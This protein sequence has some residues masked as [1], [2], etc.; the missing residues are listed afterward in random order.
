M[1]LRPWSEVNMTIEL[2]EMGWGSQDDIIRQFVS[3]HAQV[4]LCHTATDLHVFSQPATCQNCARQVVDPYLL[5]ERVISHFSSAD[6]LLDKLYSSLLPTVFF[7]AFPIHSSFSLSIDPSSV[8]R[9]ISNHLD[10][11]IP[12][13]CKYL[14]HLQDKPCWIFAYTSPS[15]S[16]GTQA[17]ESSVKIWTLLLC[18][19]DLKTTSIG[20]RIIITGIALYRKSTLQCLALLSI[21]S[22]SNPH[23]ASYQEI[24]HRKP[25]DILPRIDRPLHTTDYHIWTLHLADIFLIPTESSKCHP[26]I[27]TWKIRITVVTLLHV[28]QEEIGTVEIQ[29]IENQSFENHAENP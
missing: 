5:A 17:T 20:F 23:W 1:L 16:F 11:Y 26:I 25:L 2:G 3:E 22:H 18:P 28:E 12:G 4:A 6:T 7:L 29:E 14:W 15:A 8:T 10:R 24:Y 21:R 19:L 9:T 13:H 27:V